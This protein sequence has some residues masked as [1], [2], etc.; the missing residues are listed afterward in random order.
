MTADL[1]SSPHA[2]QLILEPVPPTTLVK[3]PTL[4]LRPHSR[5]VELC[6]PVPHA[7][8]FELAKLGD[9]LFEEPLMVTNAG[10][11]L[12]DYK[13]WLLACEQGRPYVMCLRHPLDSDASVLNLLIDLHLRK[14][15]IQNDF[16]RI[17][18]A[19]ELEPIL[20]AQAKKNQ[21]SGGQLKSSSNLTTDAPIDV[22]A[23]IARRAQVSSGNV[24]KA[25]QI[26][27]G[28]GPDLMEALRSGE[29]SIHRAHQ[30]SEY[31]QA[32]Q[33]KVLLDRRA[34]QDIKSHI[35]KL[36]NKHTRSSASRSL[37]TTQFVQMLLL[38]GGPINEVQ[39]EIIQCQG[40]RIFISD[41]LYRSLQQRDKDLSPTSRGQ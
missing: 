5:Y 37:N 23:E 29:I 21:R 36:L 10:T 6:G 33:R 14:P 2:S 1:L 28:A 32:Q 17:V 18:L 3:W 12:D 40:R 9:R 7:A 16:Q 22:R 13:R 8:L 41:E 31:S 26:L 38:D 19:L 25:K 11:I 35:A 15:T 39:V 4:D 30:W 34:S 24:T 20:R 27:V